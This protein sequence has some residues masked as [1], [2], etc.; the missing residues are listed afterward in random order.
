ML[1]VVILGVINANSNNLQSLERQYVVHHY[2]ERRDAVQIL[3][4][5]AFI[6]MN[7]F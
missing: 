1:S 6:I 3:L 5:I 7:N 2:A 4:K